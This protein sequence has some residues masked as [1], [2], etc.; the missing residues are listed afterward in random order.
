[1]SRTPTNGSAAAGPPDAEVA[2]L[3]HDLRMACMRVSRR[4]RFESSDVLAPHQFSVLARLD[5]SPRT[6]G[7]LAAIE[8]VSAPSM[9]KTVAGLAEAGLVSRSEDPRDGRLVRLALTD[10]GGAVL[11]RVRAER[12]AWMTAR[13]EDLDVED[14]VL[15]R[16]ATD[17]LN[18]VV[19]P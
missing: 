18:Q 10:E 13:L 1:M 3:A 4:V 11:A 16:R 19:R 6:V 14:R 9:S 7:E 8:R 12:D 5:E 17:L 15:L 2:R